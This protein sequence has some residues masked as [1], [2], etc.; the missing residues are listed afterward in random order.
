MKKYPHHLIEL[1]RR[2]RKRSTPAEKMLLER[3]RNRKLGQYKFVRQFH[4]ERYIADFYCRQL[5]LVVEV[6][7]GIHDADFQKKNDDIRFE[8]LELHGHRILRFRNEEVLENIETVLQKI[9]AELEKPSPQPLSH[10]GRGEIK[11]GV[12]VKMENHE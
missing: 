4:V 1:S 2:L 7:G 11:N 3:L 12:R 9:L 5:K 10:F 8:E 6:E